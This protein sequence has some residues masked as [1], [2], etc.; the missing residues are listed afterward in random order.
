MDFQ[1][2]C[3]ALGF[4]VV[5]PLVVMAGVATPFVVCLWWILHG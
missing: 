2:S 3:A 1:E 5:L 4:Y